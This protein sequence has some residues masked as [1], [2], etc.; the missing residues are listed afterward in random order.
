M[1]IQDI[2]QWWNLI[3][4]APL[5]VSLIW[6]L[7]AMFSGAHGHELSHGGHGLGHDIGHGIG[8][9]AHDVGHAV[10]NAVHH[11]DVHH[12]EIG[13]AHAAHNGTH[14]HEAH[15]HGSSQED[16]FFLRFLTILGIGQV[17]ITLIIGVFMLCWGAFGMLANQLFEGM[18]KYPAIY[19]WPSM[20]VTF[21]A[22]SVF[23]R[24][25]AGIVAKCLP[26]TETYGVSRMELIGTLG[27]TVY[28]TSDHAGTINTKD[29][30]GTVHRVQAK[31]ED[32]EEPIPSG[33]EV[34]VVDFDEEDKRFIVRKSTL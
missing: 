17:P 6:I 24:A 12:G 1:G 2:L 32:G 28:T 22:S 5:F 23:T 26:S 15:A 11:G 21:L 9:A 7:A 16:S 25:M 8:N 27:S 18:M 19:I 10:G 31:T 29:M 13:H 30:Y 20:G 34:I 3:Y 14:G 4:I 33:T